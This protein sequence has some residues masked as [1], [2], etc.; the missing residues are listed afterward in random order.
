M[1]LVDFLGLNEEVYPFA[2]FYFNN[3]LVNI[4]T[5]FLDKSN[6]NLDNEFIISHI[7]YEHIFIKML[8]KCLRHR[9]SNIEILFTDDI[10]EIRY[11]LNIESTPSFISIEK[12]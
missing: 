5:N 9:F 6:Y 7:K 8:I 4:T 12:F 10:V 11:K 1:I 3:S 2:A